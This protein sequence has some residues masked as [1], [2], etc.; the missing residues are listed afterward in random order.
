MSGTEQEAC[1]ARADE[2]LAAAKQRAESLKP[3]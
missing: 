1:K 3:Q 2:E